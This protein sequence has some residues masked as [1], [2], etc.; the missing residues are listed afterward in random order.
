MTRRELLIA[1]AAPLAA[2]PP[3]SPLGV[4]ST[5]WMSYRRFRDTLELIEHAASIGASGV[6]AG[7]SA[8]DPGYLRRVRESCERHGLYFEAMVS[9]PKTDTAQFERTLRA[10]KECG[11]LCARAA[12]LGGRRYETFS[13]LAEWKAFV[14]QSR[15]SLILAIPAAERIGIPFAIENHKDWTLDELHALLREYS[16]ENFGVCLDTGNNISLLDEPHELAETLAPWALSTHIK[17]MA[18]QDAP[19]GFLLA[20]APLG[21]GFLDLARIIGAIRKARPRTKLTLE[22]I[23]R[24]PLRV[25]CLTEKYWATFNARSAS[26]LAATLRLARSATRPIPTDAALSPRAR[27]DWEEANVRAC[28][29]WARRHIQT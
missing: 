6:Q 14:A 24:N 4:A 1:G 5:C 9:L 12:C 19:D 16:S 13:T 26:L 8:L 18:L 11:A 21:E 25:P 29:A 15:R 22:M 20:E 10:A 28:L 7:L 17:D 2:A 23:T 3:R 27:I